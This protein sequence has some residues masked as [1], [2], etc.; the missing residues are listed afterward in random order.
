VKPAAV[1]ALQQPE[2]TLSL[3]AASTLLGYV[4]CLRA[5]GV[6]ICPG[7]A[8]TY[9]TASRDRVVRRLPTFHVGTPSQSEVD[10]V[11]RTTG[12]LIASYLTEPD[13]HHAANAW[14]YLCSDPDY[15]LGALAPAMQRNVRRALRELT[16]APLGATELLAHGAPAFCD[17]R[18]RNGLD[19]GSPS[20]FRRYFESRVD[21]PGRAYLGAWKN[22]HLAA[23]V[24]VLQVDDWAELGCFSMDAMLWCRPNDALLYVALCKY[25]TERSCRVVSY[26]LSSIQAR[27][28]AGGLHRFKRKVGFEPS[29]VHRAFVF[30]PALRALANDVTLTAAHW[31]VN[32]ALRVR[33]RDRRLKKLGGMLACMLG[34]TS[35]MQAA[36][37]GG[38]PPQQDSLC[39]M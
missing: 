24:T 27:S 15:S 4:D 22:S 28:K 2:P 8:G 3:P 7:S 20:G 29:P 35:M 14:L 26:G 39:T 17:T 6:Q 38:V 36:E 32:H 18:R 25:L 16:I 10:R 33:P 19:D 23:F 37:R 9:W 11:L 5:A 1:D 34:A 12:G 31:T 30:H 13:E 21:R